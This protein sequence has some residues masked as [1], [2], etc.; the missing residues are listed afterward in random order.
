MEVRSKRAVA[1][2]DSIA[3]ITHIYIYIHIDVYLS[4]CN[5]VPE[6]APLRLKQRRIPKALGARQELTKSMPIADSSKVQPVYSMQ[7]F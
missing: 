7:G 3:C 2:L 5:E 4:H 1:V 6:G